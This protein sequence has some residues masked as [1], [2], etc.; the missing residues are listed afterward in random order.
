MQFMS[1]LLK[2]ATPMPVPVASPVALT[3]WSMPSLKSTMR[4]ISGLLAI[5]NGA[6]FTAGRTGNRPALYLVADHAPHS[7]AASTPDRMFLEWDEE[8]AA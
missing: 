8:G 2:A 1:Y 6:S 4:L 3:V 7:L 5:L